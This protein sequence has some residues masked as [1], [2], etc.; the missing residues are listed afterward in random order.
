MHTRLHTHVHTQA[1]TYTNKQQ[2]QRIE[3]S[4]K[5]KDNIGL[6]FLTSNLQNKVGC[7]VT[8]NYGG[9]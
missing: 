3:K 1:R 5:Q 4:T 9:V 6:F 8:R 7:G 2:R